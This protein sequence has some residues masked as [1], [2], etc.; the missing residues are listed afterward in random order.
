MAVI[1]NILMKSSIL[2]HSLSMLM[3]HCPERHCCV[4]YPPV[5]HLA[6][7]GLIR[8][9]QYLSVSCYSKTLLSF[10]SGFKEQ[11]VCGV[12]CGQAQMGS[13]LCFQLPTDGLRCILRAGRGDLVT[14][15]R[16]GSASGE[17]GT[18]WQTALSFP[19]LNFKSV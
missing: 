6:A 13:M 17:R 11:E 12:Q 5:C 3:C 2:L 4:H 19:V 1:S 10:D 16:S 9:S 14:Q 7:V 8:C 18:N 15:Y